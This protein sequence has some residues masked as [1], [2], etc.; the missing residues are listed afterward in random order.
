MICSKRGDMRTRK[1]R[2]QARLDSWHQQLPCLVDTYLSWKNRCQTSGLPTNNTVHHDQAMD[3]SQIS[4]EA[5]LSW[6][7]RVL[8]FDRKCIVS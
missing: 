5:E 6:Q 3:E 7:I 1:D 2:I 8:D 4:P